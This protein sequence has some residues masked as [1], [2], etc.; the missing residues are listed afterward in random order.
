MNYKFP[1]IRNINDVLPHIEGREEFIV[2]EREFGTV[3][4]YMVSMPDTFGSVSIGSKMVKGAP[5]EFHYDHSSLIRRE[6]RG[7]KFYPNGEIAARVFHKWFNIGEREETLPHNIDM[8]KPH[9]I[10]EKLDGSMLH[11]MIV[12]ERIR[13]MTKM[14]LTEVSAQA[15][16]YVIKNP[17]YQNFAHWCIENSLT[18]MFEW[19]SLKQRIVISYPEDKLVLLAV[20]N[21][22]TGEYLNV[23][24]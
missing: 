9:T 24:G 11:P 10:E 6:C 17:K 8:T 13:W 23:T 15:E 20:R 3:I 1:V 12:G 21:N 19:C 5:K 14:G 7:I 22:I 16:E 4:N 18:P 2:A